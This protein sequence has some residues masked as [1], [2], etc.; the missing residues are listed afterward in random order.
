MSQENV[1]IAQRAVAAWNRG[2]V[3]GYLA[4]FHP[5]CEWYSAVA[6]KFEGEEA[7]YRGHDE[8]RRFWEDWHSVWDL[9]IEIDEYR[10]LGH[11]VLMLGHL[12]AHGKG[13]GIDLDVPVAYLG[14]ENQGG[15]IRKLRAF[16]N[17]QEALEAVG[18]SE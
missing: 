11:S 8:L 16:L 14:S 3:E 1:E 17:P 12:R 15:L 2:D 9:Q 5:D 10:D 13:S 18:L 4:C 7:V 6:G